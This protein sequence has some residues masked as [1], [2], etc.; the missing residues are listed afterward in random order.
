MFDVFGKF[1]DWRIDHEFG[2]P[3]RN[4]SPPL[5]PPNYGDW[6]EETPPETPMKTIIKKRKKNSRKKPR[7]KGLFKEIRCLLIAQS[8][9]CSFALAL[10]IVGSM[11]LFQCPKE[12]SIPYFMI[13]Q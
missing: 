11:K 2:P 4:D 9:I 12:K 7:T 5:R 10:V 3:Q 8:I 6:T 13:G 1:Q